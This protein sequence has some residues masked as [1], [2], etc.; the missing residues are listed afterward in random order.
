MPVSTRIPA[1]RGAQANPI[2]SRRSRVA[3]QSTDPV[4]ASSPVVAQATCGEQG[5]TKS[6]KVEKIAR[7]TGTIKCCRQCCLAAH[8]D[9]HKEACPTHATRLPKAIKEAVDRL[10][11]VAANPDVIDDD[12]LAVQDDGVEEITSVSTTRSSDSTIALLQSQ[13]VNLRNSVS[14]LQGQLAS[15]TESSGPVSASLSSATVHDDQALFRNQALGMSSGQQAH[16][17]SFIA[18]PVSDT[19]TLSMHP[20]VSSSAS[21][22]S[23]SALSRLVGQELSQMLTPAAR[24][25]RLIA[26]LTG[27]DKKFSSAQELISAVEDLIS[28]LCRPDGIKSN[29]VLLARSTRV[30]R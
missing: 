6:G 7:C 17:R 11:Y 2:P 18:N 16:V 21:S 1:A 30:M 26:V 14:L 23:T 13:I 15:T 19:N 3:P 27:A 9:N 22:S 24:E 29:D 12:S 5:C 28:N 25:Q 20:S 10:R 8:F 4:L